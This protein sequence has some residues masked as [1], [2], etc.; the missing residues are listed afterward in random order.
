[1]HKYPL[2]FRFAWQAIL[3]ISFI[4]IGAHLT[5]P[6]PRNIASLSACG[7]AMCSQS[8]FTTRE[9]F[10]SG[11]FRVPEHVKV[12]SYILPDH[13]YLSFINMGEI[14][15]DSIEYI[16]AQNYLGF[17]NSVLKELDNAKL[18]DDIDREVNQRSFVILNTPGPLDRIM[19]GS[20]FLG[21]A[22]IAF[23]K[24]SDEKLPFQMDTNRSDGDNERK[25]PNAWASEIG[26]LTIESNTNPSKR[27]EI[28]K[29]AVQMSIANMY[30]YEVYVHTS[31]FQA[32]IYRKMD[33]VPAEITNLDN[34]NYILRY[35]LT[36]W[37]QR[38]L[39]TSSVRVSH[40]DI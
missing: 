37:A 13:S 22:R 30:I 10:L 28:L 32:R 6:T 24:S 33:L 3:G 7:S 36:G 35:D 27:L 5:K 21:G 23:A 19:Q 18:L 39:M 25:Y 20:D 14:S 34:L 8:L 26:A 12:F 15:R 4:N 29:A 9:K 31:K 38:H 11:T 2:L 16:S 1:M 17:K 40:L